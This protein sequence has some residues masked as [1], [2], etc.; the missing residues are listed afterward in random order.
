M[1]RTKILIVVGCLLGFALAWIPAY[2]SP[3]NKKITV[4]CNS[5]M[6]DE[7]SGSATV[8]LCSSIDL[9]QPIPSDQCVGPT[10]CPTSMPCD[11]LNGPISVTMPCAASSKVG[12]VY[13][14]ITCSDGTEGSCGSS[15]A[16]T[17]NGKG[18]V[19][20]A[21]NPDGDGITVTV[22]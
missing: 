1:K 18:T 21:S 8:T 17:L 15:H 11:S 5:A 2:A 12:G 14:V 20:G 13:I 7:V 16:S 3:T 4:T 9:S 19:L 6:G 22:K 10:D